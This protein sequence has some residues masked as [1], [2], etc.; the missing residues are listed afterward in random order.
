MRLAR[1]NHLPPK[2]SS[3]L[4]APT[5]RV[6]QIFHSIMSWSAEDHPG[7]SRFRRVLM[8]ATSCALEKGCFLFGTRTSS[9]KV[10]RT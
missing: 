3:A 5:H 8:M 9:S 2:Q 4:R 6:K 1:E 7:T 10:W